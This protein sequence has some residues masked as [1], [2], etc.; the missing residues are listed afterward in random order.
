MASIDP[1]YRELHK[2]IDESMPV[3][4]PAS[5]DG[6]ELRILE[7]LFTPEEAKIALTLGMAPDT[8]KRIHRRVKKAGISIS[9]NELEDIL[10]GLVEK[11]AIMGGGYV[12]VLFP[13]MNKDI[14]RYSL[15]QWGIGI[16]DLQ[17]GRVTKEFAELRQ[18][19]ELVTFYQEF[20]RKDRSNQLR[21]IPVEKSLT[22]EHHVSTYDDIRNIV[23]NKVERIS[24]RECICRENHDALEEPCK[25]SDIRRCCINF[26]DLAEVTIGDGSGKEVSKDELFELL[27][28]Y[29]REGFV[30]QPHNTQN[31]MV[32]CACC[33][34]CCGVLNMAKQFPRPTE[35]YSSNF[36]AQ[37]DPEL[38]TG[39][40]TC[41][42]RCQMEAITMV[43]EKSKVNLDRCIGCGNCVATC[44]V[45]AMKLVKREE[46][47]APAKDQVELYQ[48]I[49][50][51]KIKFLEH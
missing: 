1:I 5:E 31:P 4:F 27:D 38:C 28:E 47:V 49:M 9:L 2:K 16:S 20:H 13:D 15:A 42:N 48:K 22:P 7:M 35:Y 21:T 43:D 3:G 45:S 29:Q 23:N 18:K 37:P 12:Y 6:T 11:G 30:L 33:G 17:L 10:D 19:Y 32:I 26:N 24:I 36:Y 40:E 50:E 14:K 34:C 25:L 46:E 44:E 51:K 8:L 41:V 39:C